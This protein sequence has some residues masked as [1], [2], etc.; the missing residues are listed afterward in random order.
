[1][2]II[3][4]LLLAATLI[5]S[6]ATADVK[7]VDEKWPDGSLKVRREMIDDV[8]GR[9]VQNGLETHYYS[10]GAKQSETTYRFGVPDG[11]WREYYMSGKV[12]AEGAI[13]RG[14]KDGLET[15]YT[16]AGDKS[17]QVTYQEGKRNG[18]TTKWQG[19]RKIF[20]ADYDNDHLV[21][22]LQQWYGNGTPRLVQ[23]YKAGV[24]DGPE[25]RWFADGTKFSVAN[26]TAGQK[27]GEFTEWHP[28]G[29]LKYHTTYK[30][31]QP[32]GKFEERFSDGALKGTGAYLDG[33]PDGSW[34]EWFELDEL[35]SDAKGETASPDKPAAAEEKDAAETKTRQHVLAA[36]RNYHRGKLNGKQITYHKNGQ[37]QLEI[38]VVEDRR[39][40]PYVEWYDSGQVRSEGKY[41]HD[42]P[43]GEATFWYDDGKPW[44]VY[45]YFRGRPVGRWVQW[46]RDGNII[47]DENHG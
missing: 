23:Q 31:G 1:M 43:D 27:D 9:P 34:K 40:G 47:N 36:E 32:N 22:T 18:K 2:L 29:Q 16:E 37:K 30:N 26:Y 46:D 3:K 5:S 44:A 35:P 24:L 20:E 6:A 10:G 11:P 39:E 19:G 38:A 33:L 12:K 28:N 7:T 21:G 45:N 14:Q 8:R 17:S 42:Q 41:F 15:T 25:Y 4:T 13:H